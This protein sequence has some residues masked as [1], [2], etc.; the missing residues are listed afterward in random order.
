MLIFSTRTIIL[1][2]YLI[3]LT[4]S[5]LNIISPPELKDYFNQKYGNDSEGIPYS[6][7]NFGD[8]PYGRT[9]TG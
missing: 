2:T 9:L 3:L 7:A 6:I 5:R 8:V 1:S 4:F